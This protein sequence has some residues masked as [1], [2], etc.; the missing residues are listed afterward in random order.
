MRN[1]Y[2]YLSWT[3]WIWF[4]IAGSYLMWKM[5]SKFSRDPEGTPAGER[6]DGSNR[7]EA[8]KTE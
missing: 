7:T 3:G 1:I 4:V 2:I 5:R 8:K 6:V